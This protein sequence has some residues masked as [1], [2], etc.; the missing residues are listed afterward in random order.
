MET[1]KFRNKA[2]TKF[3]AAATAALLLCAAFSA[4]VAA[5]G[6]SGV[7]SLA[8][9]R[10]T[11]N[12]GKTFALTIRITPNANISVNSFDAVIQYDSANL[13]LVM[14]GQ[15]PKITRPSG[16]PSSFELGATLTGNQINILGNDSSLGQNAPIPTGGKETSLITFTF[17]VKDSATVGATASFAIMDPNVNE[18]QGGGPVPLLLTANSPKTAPV[19]ARLDTN[20]YLSELKTNVGTLNPAF[21]KT[22][23]EYLLEVPTETVAVTIS[24]KT[25]SSLSKATV[26]GGQNLVYGD[27]K[28]TVTVVAQDP[29]AVRTYTVTVRRAHPQASSSEETSSLS[30]S[31][32]SSESE[33]ASESMEESEPESSSESSGTTDE[34]AAALTF[35]KLIAFLFI[36]LFT[37]TAGVAVWLLIDK[38]GRNGGAPHNG[39]TPPY[40]GG[41]AD[42]PD[43][44]GGN[45]AGADY[46]REDNDRILRRKKKE[47]IQKVKI[48]RIP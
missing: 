47:K 39:G 13:D 44:L 21:S 28:V 30:E 25:E 26:A 20:T 5:E 3:L 36:G 18:L 14:D 17:K 9:S 1:I 24:A 12:I 32:V 6:N 23:T 19:G 45:A 16:V 42:S 4:P 33:S 29:D 38:F 34:T 41:G 48:R 35:W 8:L 2:L 46:N 37:V 22:K 40:G 11:L 7:M 31:S 15:Y 10:S 43:G 27:N